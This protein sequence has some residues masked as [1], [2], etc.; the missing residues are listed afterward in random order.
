MLVPAAK[1]IMT[2]FANFKRRKWV[3]EMALSALYA[4][5]VS[6]A[7]VTPESEARNS[8][9]YASFFLDLIAHVE[10]SSYKDVSAS[11]RRDLGKLFDSLPKEWVRARVEDHPLASRSP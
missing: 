7:R 2:G 3:A 6:I 5:V 11:L 8:L 1:L 10:A 4:I 9:P